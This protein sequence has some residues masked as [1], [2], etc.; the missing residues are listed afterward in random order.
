MPEFR[1]GGGDAAWR[2]YLQRHIHLP[3]TTQEAPNRFVATFIVS[4]TGA[5][6][7]ARL[8]RSSGIAALDA[9]VV[10]AIRALPPFRPGQQNGVNVSVQLSF[11]MIICLQ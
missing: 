3:A 9:E 2:Q 4:E 5:I 11:S 6:R 10:R 7:Q 8:A 1:T